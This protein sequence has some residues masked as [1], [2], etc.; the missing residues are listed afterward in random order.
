MFVERTVAN[1]VWALTNV[2]KE[3][4]FNGKQSSS[5]YVECTLSGDLANNNTDFG[6]RLWCLLTSTTKCTVNDV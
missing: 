1:G 6:W 4:P 3:I 5:L 2:E